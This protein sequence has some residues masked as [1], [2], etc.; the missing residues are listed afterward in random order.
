MNQ[1]CRIATLATLSLLVS[2]VYSRGLR[3]EFQFDDAHT[4]E[5]RRDIRNPANNLVAEW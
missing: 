3:G 5:F 2:L 1:R 4:V